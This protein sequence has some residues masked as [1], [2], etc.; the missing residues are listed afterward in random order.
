MSKHNIAEELWPNILA[1]STYSPECICHL[2][3][4]CKKFKSLIDAGE[5]KIWHICFQA[6]TH[7]ALYQYQ[8]AQEKIIHNCNLN[9][10]SKEFCALVGEKHAKLAP[11]PIGRVAPLPKPCNYKLQCRYFYYFASPARLPLNAGHYQA[12]DYV[13]S[14]NSDS[15]RFYTNQI[16]GVPAALKAAG[17]NP[18]AVNGADKPL[19]IFVYGDGY[20]RNR[21][22]D[23]VVDGELDSYRTCMGMETSATMYMVDADITDKQQA[24]REKKRLNVQMLGHGGSEEYAAML[25]MLLN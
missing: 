4:T 5:Q 24:Q 1:F 8:C 16:S 22:M 10:F 17:G 12:P 6:M 19:T 2:A 11:P 21:F 18:G 7:A 9:N 14:K 25:G 3:Q 23:A 20:E 15:Y 13:R